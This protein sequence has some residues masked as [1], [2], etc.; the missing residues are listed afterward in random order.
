MR[1]SPAIPFLFACAGAAGCATLPAS[2]SAAQIKK[3]AALDYPAKADHGDDLQVIVTREGGV[4]RLNN[5]GTVVKRDCLLW[6]N[7]QYVSLLPLL[8]IGTDNTVELTACINR[9]QEPYPVGYWLRPDL[10]QRV[11]LVELLDPATGL[12]HRL[13][14]R[15]PRDPFSEK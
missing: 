15:P 13:V 4:L 11:V 14:T 12:R 2:L 8:K 5:T 9:H 3:L 10:D 1:F 6:V 7:R